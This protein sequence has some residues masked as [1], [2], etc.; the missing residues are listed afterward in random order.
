MRKRFR[1]LRMTAPLRRLVRETH[2]HAS[3]L[4]QPLFVA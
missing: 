2:L 3:Q 4:V 1:R